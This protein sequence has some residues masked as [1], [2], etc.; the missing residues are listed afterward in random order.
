MRI[1]VPGSL[2]ADG[3]LATGTTPWGQI[4]T[5]WTAKADALLLGRTTYEIFA[6]PGRTSRTTIRSVRY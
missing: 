5:E 3:P 4:I 1:A 6:A 2:A